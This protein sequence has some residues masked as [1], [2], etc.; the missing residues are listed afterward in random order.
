MIPAFGFGRES[1]LVFEITAKQ[2]DRENI[3]ECQ[4]RRLVALPHGS[5]EFFES[6]HVF[7]MPRTQDLLDSRDSL[8]NLSGAHGRDSN[9]FNGLGGSTGTMGP[10]TPPSIV[11]VATT[12]FVSALTHSMVMTRCSRTGG[13]S[14]FS[15]FSIRRLSFEGFISGSLVTRF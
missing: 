12:D 3:G 15:P 5:A 4:K 14:L 8:A 9:E 2:F 7:V 11:L 10:V 6:K 13:V 1:I